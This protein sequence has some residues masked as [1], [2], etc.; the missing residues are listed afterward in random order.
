M[1]EREQN[2][3]AALKRAYFLLQTHNIK[4]DYFEV[5]RVG[6]GELLPSQVVDV[7]LMEAAIAH[8]KTHQDAPG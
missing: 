5:L 7:K 1:T 8:G 4:D 2:L 6:L 3:L